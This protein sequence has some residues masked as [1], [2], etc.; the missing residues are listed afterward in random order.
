VFDRLK[1]VWQFEQL[2]NA[3]VIAVTPHFALHGFISK[4]IKSIGIGLIL[5]KKHAKRAV[6][7]NNIRRQIYVIAQAFFKD[8]KRTGYQLVLRLKRSF[9]KEHYISAWSKLLKQRVCVEI[10]CL[11]NQLKTHSC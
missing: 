10:T 8:F 4:E 7:R 11:L 5:P 9:V 2:K 3:P 6:T 1:K